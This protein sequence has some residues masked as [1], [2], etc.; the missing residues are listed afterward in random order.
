MLSPLLEGARER[1]G[2]LGKSWAAKNSCIININRLK[3]NTY[4]EHEIQVTW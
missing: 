3:V 1:V 4:I 2:G